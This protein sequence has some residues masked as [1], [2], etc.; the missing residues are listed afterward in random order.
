MK[1][2]QREA[3]FAAL[4]KAKAVLASFRAAEDQDFE[5]DTIVE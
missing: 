1:A 3:N 5:D 4:E 2:A